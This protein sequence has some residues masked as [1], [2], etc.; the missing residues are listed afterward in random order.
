MRRKM[1][2]RQRRLSSLA[3]PCDRHHGIFA[4]R[5]RQFLRDMSR[6]DRQ[7]ARNPMIDKMLSIFIELENCPVIP[8][9]V[10]RRSLSCLCPTATLTQQIRAPHLPPR[11]RWRKAT[12]DLGL[13]LRIPF[14]GHF[15]CF[16]RFSWPMARMSLERTLRLHPRAS[17]FTVSE[18]VANDGRIYTQVQHAN[19]AAPS[20]TTAPGRRTIRGY[21]AGSGDREEDGGVAGWN[22]HDDKRSR[23]RDDLFREAGRRMSTITQLAIDLLR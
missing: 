13:D 10:P 14:R 9:E 20:S 1:R 22:D 6:N 15:V 18:T 8:S 17:V 5:G 3:W 7:V 12:D 23:C 19:V 21:R 11:R 2:L 16:D 4:R